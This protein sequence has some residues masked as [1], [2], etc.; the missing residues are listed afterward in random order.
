MGSPCAQALRRSGFRGRLE[1]VFEPSSHA[2]AA[3]LLRVRELGDALAAYDG[4][5]ATGAELVELITELER[6]KGRAEGAQVAAAVALD[7]DQRAEQAAAG[8]PAARR[9][10]GVGL[11]VALARRESHHRGARHL[12]LAK[13]L[14]TELPRTLEALR[15]GRISEWRAT[16]VARETAC[17]TREARAHVDRVL[18]GDVLERAGERELVA[19]LRRLAYT[20]EPESVVARRRRAESERSVSLRPAPDTMAYLTALLPVA[21]GVAALAAL[22]STAATL[23]SEGD[24]RSRGQVMAD[25]LVT[26]LLGQDDGARPQVPITVNVVVSDEVLLGPVEGPAEVDGFGPVPASLVRELVDAAPAEQAAVRRLYAR[27]A[28]AALVAMDS[29][30]RCFPR[31]LARVIRL[32][33]RTC[34][35]P[36]CNAPVRH[37]DHVQPAGSGGPTSAVNG[38]GLCEACNYAKQALGWWQRAAIGPP[39]RHTV[40]IITPTGARHRSTAPPLPRPAVLSRLELSL[41]RYLHAA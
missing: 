24:P 9:G 10:Q 3:L 25:L 27:P 20:L 18:G 1:H 34:R 40:D 41:E 7:A 38:Q 11:Q 6:L 37:V 19:E 12:G 2:V 15:H 36:W 22:T 23:R 16:L 17:L 33:D 8:V 21:D 29:R 32:R 13:V 4:L 5:G 30:S 35:T 39:G 14:T 31:A 26:R 28:D